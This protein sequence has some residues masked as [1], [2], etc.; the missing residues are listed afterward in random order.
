MDCESPCLCR[1]LLVGGVDCDSRRSTCGAHGDDVVTLVKMLRELPPSLMIRGG[2]KFYSFEQA[3]KFIADPRPTLAMG[4]DAWRQLFDSRRSWATSEIA[5]LGWIDG[6]RCADVIE[7]QGEK[8]P[9]ITW[10]RE[11]LM[12]RELLD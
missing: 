9:Q 10:A 3:V 5:C 2:Q 8:E 1:C 11:L 4:E 7:K 6:A 12:M